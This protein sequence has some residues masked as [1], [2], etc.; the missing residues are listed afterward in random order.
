MPEI[1]IQRR[2]HPNAIAQA[3]LLGLAVA[4]RPSHPRAKGTLSFHCVTRTQEVQVAHP[5]LLSIGDK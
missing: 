5:L 2:R 3:T 4:T 1:Q